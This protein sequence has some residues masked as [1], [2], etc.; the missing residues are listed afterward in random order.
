MASVELLARIV[1]AELNSYQPPVWAK[2]FAESF[3]ADGRMTIAERCKKVGIEPHDWWGALQDRQFEEWF[4]ARCEAV[5][6]GSVGV[7]GLQ[8]LRQALEFGK[9]PDLKLFMER[10]DSGYAPTQKVITPEKE[11]PLIV[12]LAASDYKATGLV[13]R[14]DTIRA[15][16][17]QGP[18]EAEL[19]P[20]KLLQKKE[21]TKK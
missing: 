20:E 4:N 15:E 19:V 17:K 18:V 10:W 14:M 1:D 5:C 11:N 13:K 6:R 16:K 8:L 7:V 21:D 2:K 9:A 3:L 12:T